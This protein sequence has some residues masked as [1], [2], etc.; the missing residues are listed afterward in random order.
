M[1]VPAPHPQAHVAPVAAVPIREAQSDAARIR[2]LSV[3][4]EAAEKALEAEDEVTAAARSDEGDVLTADWP[5]ELLKQAEVQ[6]L[7]Q[8]LKEVQDQL[9]SEASTEEEP[10]LK[11][12]EE[13]VTISD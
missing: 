3:L 8:R 9:A 1:Q 12:A 11:A 10:G 4:V 6:A 13:V 5:L 2:R 7:L